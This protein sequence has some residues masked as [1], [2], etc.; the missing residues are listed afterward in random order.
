MKFRCNK[1]KVTHRIAFPIPQQHI[2][3]CITEITAMQEGRAG[4]HRP[5]YEHIISVLNS[6]KKDKGNIMLLY[7]FIVHPNVVAVLPWLQKECMRMWKDTEE[8]NKDGQRHTTAFTEETSHPPPKEEM[9]FLTTHQHKKLRMSKVDAG[10]KPVRHF[11]ERKIH[12]GLLTTN[13]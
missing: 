2:Q 11:S 8:E 9:L 13:T 3:C 6:S 7:E 1:Y 12:Q 5:F 10:P 4:F